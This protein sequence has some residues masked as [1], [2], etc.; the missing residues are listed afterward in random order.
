M[1][2]SL[3]ILLSQK[4][5]NSAKP[6]SSDLLEDSYILTLVLSCPLSEAMLQNHEFIYW[7]YASTW[8]NL[9]TSL[10]IMDFEFR[11]NLYCLLKRMWFLMHIKLKGYNFGCCNPAQTFTWGSSD[12]IIRYLEIFYWLLLWLALSR[13]SRQ[14]GFVTYYMFVVL[15]LGFSKWLILLFVNTVIYHDYTSLNH[16]RQQCS[17]WEFPGP[18][19]TSC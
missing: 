15:Y 17:S 13:G 5:S 8:L 3:L 11:P 10:Q 14:R 16:S 2:K 19:I 7:N 1:F 6:L 9:F 18:G 12:V 4:L